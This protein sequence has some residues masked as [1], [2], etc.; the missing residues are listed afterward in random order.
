MKLNKERQMA[1]RIVK[2]AVVLLLLSTTAAFAQEAGQVVTTTTTQEAFVPGSYFYLAILVGVILAV[3]FELILTHLSVAAGISAVGPLDRRGRKEEAPPEKYEEAPSV[4]GRV[5]KTTSLFG[6]WTLVTA[7]IS[8]FFASWLAVRLAATPNLFQGLVLGLAIWGLFYVTMTV[9]E[10]TALTSLVGS[11]VQTAIGG[12]KS[13][14]KATTSVFGKSEEDRVAD[15]AEKVTAA[16][17]EELFG[18]IDTKD[19]RKQIEGYIQQVKP[20]AAHDIKRALSGLLDE[21]EIRAIV[22]HEEGPFAD[23]DVLTAS[24]E[25]DTGM[26]REKARSLATG[27]KDAIS[28]IRAEYRSDKDKV[29]KATDAAM[30]VTGKSEEEARALREQIETYL[31]DTPKEELN[32]EAIRRDLEKVL[33]SPKEGLRTLRGRLAPI[34][35][36]T[37]S[38]ILAQRKDMTEQEA[39][40]IADRVMSVIDRMRSKAEEAPGPAEAQKRGVE[41]KIRNYLN[42]MDRPELRYEGIEHD[43]QVLFHDPKAAADLLIRRLKALDRNTLQAIV[44]SRRDISEE[45]AEHIVSQM[46]HARDETVA[47]YE[48]MK[49]EVQHRLTDAKDRA[50]RQAEETR[51]TAQTAAWWTFGSAVASAA[52]AVI[53]GILSTYT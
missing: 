1:T 42:S 38:A 31:R 33:T 34:D 52:A 13:A 30:R 16:V 25:T 14:Y 51:K 6:I 41:A 5:K 46:E 37:L 9:L 8:L 48:Q 27:V 36:S 20:A 4:M 22:E 21:T 53:G 28:K 35:R 12:L 43:M 19:L 24:L 10:V 40:K 50:L 11:L 2:S 17:R 47:K 44:A 45:D 29:S 18:D 49:A 15:T 3:S 39:N 26:T 32:P 7:T 23:V